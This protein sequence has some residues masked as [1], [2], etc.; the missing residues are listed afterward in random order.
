MMHIRSKE[1][2]S[3]RFYKKENSVRQEHFHRTMHGTAIDKAG[4]VEQC[5]PIGQQLLVL[6]QLLIA[7]Q[8][9]YAAI[10]KHVLTSVGKNRVHITHL[11]ES[12]LEFYV[13]TSVRHILLFILSHNKGIILTTQVSGE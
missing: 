10:K 12:I 9:G 8:S 13:I 4:T 11:Q 5:R 2:T 3:L 1:E 6:V 7:T